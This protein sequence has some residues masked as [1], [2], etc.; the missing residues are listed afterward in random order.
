MAGKEENT[1]PPALVAGSSLLPSPFA[2][3]LTRGTKTKL[4]SFVHY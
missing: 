3:D 2:R 4:F 1:Q